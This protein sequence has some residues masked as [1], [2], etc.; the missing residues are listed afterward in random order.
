MLAL[1]GVLETGPMIGA[2]GSILGMLAAGAI[3]FPNAIVLVMFVFPMRL[4]ILAIILAVISILKISSG[5]NQGGEVAHLAGMAAG[6]PGRRLR[7][8][9][10]LLGIS[11][12]PLPTIGLSA[13]GDLLGS[14]ATPH[15][16]ATAAT[17][18]SRYPKRQ[19]RGQ[20]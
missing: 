11:V 15:A 3:L 5:F 14:A 13:P 7:P 6:A 9:R 18:I 19:R 17:Q 2:S 10:A 12:G 20:G 4:R 1:S 8:T 16:A